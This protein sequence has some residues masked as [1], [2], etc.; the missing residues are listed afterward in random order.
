MKIEVNDKII[1]DEIL[2]KKILYP[3]L[4]VVVLLVSCSTQPP[5]NFQ[6]LAL[7]ANI[8]P[9]YDSLTIPC[10]IAPLNF[11]I[12]DTADAYI[13]RVYAP[14]GE[15]FCIKG[16]K[17]QMDLD[18]WKHM[19]ENNKGKHYSVDIFAEKNGEWSKY[20]TITNIIA[21][22]TIDPYISYRLIE[23][24]YMT[25]EVLSI[26]QRNITNF[27]TKEI[28]NNFKMTSS[29]TEGQCVN[30]HSYQNYRTGNMQFHV[31][32]HKGGTVI[33][34][35]GV[36]VKVNTKTDSTISGGVYASW[37]PTEKLIA[38]S[39][40][41]IGQVF[42]S[43]SVE[44]VEVVDRNSDIVLYDVD[45]NQISP[46]A[47][48]KGSLESWPS[49]SPDGNT[50]Y[51]VS[52]RF[53]PQS[54]KVDSE[55][56][57]A[58]NKIRYNVMRIPFDKK[59]GKF[60]KQDTVFSA[61]RIGKSAS[62]PRVSPDGRYMMLTLG[63]YGNFHI[64]HKSADIYLLDMKI[65]IIRNMAEVNSSDVESYHSW[66][67]NGRWIIISTRRD[68][69]SY[70]RSYISYFDKKGMGTKPFM[71]PQED[72]DFYPQF[73]KS[74]NIPEFMVE[75]VKLSVQDFYNAI[76]KDPVKATYKGI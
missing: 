52:A 20:K 74:F 4:F 31:R 58:Y 24:G 60:G 15:E 66:S 48:D 49:W 42:H 75:P 36:A 51:F 44:K 10:N 17:V 63:D 71:L 70:T 68:D 26:N 76:D 50:L 1:I 30:C 19:L 53:K 8:Y 59:T 56:V 29:D 67:S 12:K 18:T 46:I 3:F 73:F 23:P 7:S 25:Y 45:K 72:P 5:T 27:E 33:V 6:N 39:V 55:L 35:D 14:N 32:Q 38:Y 41:S 57:N 43:K 54:E 61:S 22:E 11:K 47:T 16:Q 64:W 34:S 28:Y 2:M 13:S 21:G 9:D 69:G 62:F 40:N 37:H 65:G